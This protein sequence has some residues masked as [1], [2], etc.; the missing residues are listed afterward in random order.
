M[1][2]EVDEDVGILH[3]SHKLLLDDGVIVHIIGEIKDAGRI[4]TH[5]HTVYFLY[6]RVN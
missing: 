6:D 3:A 1:F 2:D 4:T 5:L